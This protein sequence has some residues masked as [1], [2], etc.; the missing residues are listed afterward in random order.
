M[1]EI[2]NSFHQNCIPECDGIEHLFFIDD[3]DG[4]IY[5][6]IGTFFHTKYWSG[7]NIY[8]PYPLEINNGSL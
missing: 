6:V 5:K 1:L 8:G 4:Y 2:K 3:E 7:K